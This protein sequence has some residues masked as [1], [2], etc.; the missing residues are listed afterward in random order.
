M[1]LDPTTLP[2]V[3]DP[4]VP[5]NLAGELTTIA[6]DAGGSLER[7]R[8]CWTRL[9]EVFFVDGAEGLPFMLNGLAADA[10]DFACALTTAQGVLSEAAATTLP[11]LQRRRDELAARMT[12]VSEAMDRARKRLQAASGVGCTSVSEY[13]VDE[14]KTQAL[15]EY[16]AALHE[17]EAVEEE[18]RRF[19]DDVEAA[20]ELLG[21]QLTQISG[22]DEVHG[23]DRRSLHSAQSFWG[24]ADPAA[25]GSP[26]T[27]HG[28]ADH[29]SRT[30]SAATERRVRWLSQA[31]T[32]EAKAWLGDHPDF[33]S[34]VGLIDPRRAAQLF[35]ELASTSSADADGTWQSGPLSRLLVSSPLAIA[36]L[37]GIALQR[38]A[39]ARAGLAQLQSDDSLTPAAEEALNAVSGILQRD[40]RTMLL[41]LHLDLDGSL[42]TTMSVGNPDAAVQTTTLSHGIATDTR[43]LEQWLKGASTLQS[44]L[45]LELES[46]GVR[47][48][49]SMVMFFEWDS[50][51]WTT[52]QR[53][54]RPAAGAT[55]LAALIEGFRVANP[56]SQQNLVLHS[57]GTTMGVDA[58]ARHKGLVDNMWLLGSAGVTSHD[59]RALTEQLSAGQVTVHA[60]SAPADGIAPL[61]RIPELSQHDV[62]PRSLA[63]VDVFASDDSPAPDGTQ[64]VTGHDAFSRDRQPARKRRGRRA[65]ATVG[66]LGEDSDTFADL[67]HQLLNAATSGAH[68]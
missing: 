38:D 21:S 51:D 64:H 16:T 32:N 40:P 8:E 29:L 57:L 23:K 67:V 55:R 4:A 19:T 66:Y 26:R 68:P 31:E 20:E 30:L 65:P 63:G 47:G 24:F 12:P 42:R 61:G 43:N 33:A 52:V 48:D 14:E 46:R 22:G 10:S 7:A 60:S 2:E 11:E 15:R 1:T 56:G 53:M 39:F 36:N 35:D 58:V 25:P 5:S 50:G 62:D 17:Y 49:T 45:G 18:V 6:A 3:I 41:S 27:T 44:H 37:N 9:S 54:E 13:P 59:G 34:A 28:L